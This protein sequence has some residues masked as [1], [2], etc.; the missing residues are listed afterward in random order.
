[1][2][3]GLFNNI[4]RKIRPELVENC[5]RNAMIKIITTFNPKGN[6]IISDDALYYS[7]LDDNH[8][9]YEHHGHCDF[10]ANKESTS[11][12]EQLWYHLKS[13]I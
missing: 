7:S 11:N 4:S 8:C 9:G 10:E 5:T 3:F 13:I 1:M 12:I 6:I 2:I